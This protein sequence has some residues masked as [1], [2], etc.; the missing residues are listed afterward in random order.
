[1][2]RREIVRT[3]IVGSMGASQASKQWQPRESSGD[4][5]LAAS[6]S[7]YESS[8]PC[9]A[10][11]ALCIGL[12][13]SVPTFDL[14]RF[15]GRSMHEALIADRSHHAEGLA[16]K[17]E[18]SEFSLL[19]DRCGVKADKGWVEETVGGIEEEIRTLL[20]VCGCLVGRWVLSCLVLCF[21]AV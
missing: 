15:L 5:L 13:K 20:E 14:A 4:S 3:S 19:A 8:K 18:R 12:R 2:S 16:G 17:V 21:A 6:P 1:M 7:C 9:E 10:V 11:V